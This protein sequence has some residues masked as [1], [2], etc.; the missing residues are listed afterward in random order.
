MNGRYI[1]KTIKV[2]LKDSE[3]EAVKKAMPML[4]AFRHLIPAGLVSVVH[5]VEEAINGSTSET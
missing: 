1:V 3:M 5:K 4:H 2:T